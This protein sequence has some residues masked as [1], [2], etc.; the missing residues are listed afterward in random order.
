[1]ANID[2]NAKEPDGTP[3]VFPGVAEY[4][5]LIY[6]NRNEDIDGIGVTFH[7]NPSAGGSGSETQVY[8]Y[9][10]LPDLNTSNEYVQERVLSLLKECIDAGIDGFRF[11]AAKH[12][13]TEQDPQFPS[14]FWDSTL[15]PAKD[16]YRSL[17]GGKEL[18]VYGEILNGTQGRDLSC[19][20][21]HMRITDDGFLAQYKGVYAKKDPLVILNAKL[22]T[23]DATQLIAWVESHD[24]YVT[25]NTH[26]SDVRVARFWSVIA[27]KKGLGGLYLA[28]PT[29]ELT[30]GEIGS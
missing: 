4:E 5:P 10:N 22:K 11:D 6:N 8:A 27:A 26:Y 21:D 3:V 18:Y 14:D 7:H 9:G 17:T 30:V 13:E 15:E 2:D 1:M 24:E 29:A 28:R 20:T 25:T 19:Y 23:D 12:I 16:Y